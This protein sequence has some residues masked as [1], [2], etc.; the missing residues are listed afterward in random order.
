[1]SEPREIGAGQIHRAAIE[2]VIVAAAALLA[3]CTVGPN[4][5]PP[6]TTDVPGSFNEISPADAARHAQRAI[7]AQTA[8]TNPTT[9][10][11]LDREQR[12]IAATTRPADMAQWWTTF[13]DPKLDLLI[14]QAI[15][16]N[17]DLRAANQRILQA[18]AARS[19]T[20][21][22]LFPEID[23]TGGFDHE[24]VSKNAGIGGEVSSLGGAGGGGAATGAGT[25]NPAFHP[26]AVRAGAA[27]PAGE[28]IVTNQ[29]T[30]GSSG[31][32]AVNFD[33]WNAGFDAS[34]EVDVFGGTRR[35]IEAADYQL[36]AS[37]EDRR[38]VLVTL[39]GEVARNYVE[40]RGAQRELAITE[41]NLQAQNDT[42]ELT[43]SR[44]RAGIGT[45][46]DVA[47]AEGEAATT[48]AD[49]PPL[50]NQIKMAIHRLSVLTGQ[51]PNAL[52]AELAEPGPVPEGSPNV[53]VGLPSELLRR[54]PDVRRAERQLAAATANVGVATADL[55]P[56]FNLTA[57][58]GDE[59]A[60][61]PNLFDRASFGWS[62]G[63]SATWDILDF[64][65]VTSNIQVQN[66]LQAQALTAYQSTVLT[67]LEDVSDALVGYDRELMRRVALARATDANRRAYELVDQ[68]F[69]RG[70]IIDFLTVLDAQRAMFAAEVQL[71]QSDTAVSQDL[72]ALYKALGGGWEGPIGGPN[73]R[74]GMHAS[75][76]QA[77]K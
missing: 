59:S 29:A 12:Q 13:N 69:T 28:P 27:K 15:A 50:E 9:S 5:H 4:Y 43:R 49:I 14:H 10:A 32:Q 40:L 37:I 57:T 67:S 53:P 71:V 41:Q 18:R 8:A 47:R 24:T 16:G 60:R 34:W 11:V 48:E 55:F 35:A 76:Q 75:P 1:M 39:L 20:T 70:G 44:Y 66:Q 3:G 42:L 31:N 72:V 26:S 2:L 30:S 23:A 73:D 36:Q 17:L 22:N 64:G 62:L 61:L 46:L 7:A 68:Q 25:R 33:L 52:A 51:E 56:K 74:A 21:A 45:D 19:G 63:P 54:R 38:D 6:K 77:S 58:A 65:R